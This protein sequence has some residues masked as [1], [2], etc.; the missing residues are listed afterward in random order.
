MKFEE[1]PKMIEKDGQQIIVKNA[2][3]EQALTLTDEKPKR[4]YVRKKSDV[5]E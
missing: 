4:K 1:Y 2:E 3:E 5:A